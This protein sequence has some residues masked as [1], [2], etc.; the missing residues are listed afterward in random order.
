MKTIETAYYNAYKK[1]Y[2]N[3]LMDKEEEKIY[4]MGMADG[5]RELFEYE[6]GMEGELEKLRKT[7]KFDAKKDYDYYKH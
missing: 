5:L 4:F 2:F 7:A 6:D 1:Y 3:W